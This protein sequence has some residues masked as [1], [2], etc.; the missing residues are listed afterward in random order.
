MRTRLIAILLFL[1]AAVPALAGIRVEEVTAGADGYIRGERWIPVVF[2]LQGAGGSFQGVIEV[3]RGNTIFR[4]S[5]DLGAG[6]SKRVELMVYQSSY[7]DPIEYRI[8]DSQEK[9]ITRNRID[10]RILNYQDNVLLVIS[11]T[12]FS[13]QF[14]NGV[15]NPWGGKTF[16][17]YMDPGQMFSEPI[18]YSAVDAVALGNVSLPEIAPA[19]R[20]ALLLYAATGGTLICSA[21]TNLSVLQDPA[22]RYVLPS[23]SAELTL[24]NHGEFLVSRWTARST[25]AFPALTIPA[26]EVRPGPADN[27]L[28][29]QTADLSLVTSS[30]FYKGNIIYFAFDYTRMPEDVGSIFPGYWNDLIYPTTSGPPAFGRPFRQ[31]LENNPR[32]QRFLYNIP[33]L[34]LPDV[35]WFALFFFVYLIAIGPLQ[36]LILTRLKKNALL[37][38]TFPVIILAFTGAALG[39]GKFR[40]NTDQRIR[41]VQVLDA[42][43][44]LGMQ[45][46]Y[47]AFGTALSESGKFTYQAVPENSF[48]T[49]AA[50]QAF[51]YLPEP[52]TLSEDLPHCIV[53]ENVKTWT[54][55]TF[56]AVSAEPLALP[57]AVTAEIDG[58][59]LTGTV[60]NSGQTAITNSFFVYD[61]KNSAPIGRLNAGGTLPFSLELNNTSPPPF[62]ESHLRGLLDLHG[63]SLTN[64]HFFFGEILDEPGAIAIN[65]QDRPTDCLQYIAVYINL[66]QRGPSNAWAP[67][68]GSP[69]VYR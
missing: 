12:D 61:S 60:T 42:F 4:K 8:R 34:A 35:K 2:Q 16:V 19:A 10:T 45:Y 57:V 22:V 14:L 1:S 47:Q 36:Y 18:A 17:S 62:A 58:G 53:G 48:M 5:V 27:V 54:Y 26:Q 55:R 6:A 51:T 33:G 28:V 39:Y 69:M 38:T 11:G 3:V 66:R 21:A 59:K 20:K 15:Q 25:S 37:W 67:D 7:Y 49:K 56:D 30:P 24:L 13:H 46:R 31:R 32:A 44:S 65:G 63:L 43:P 29:A 64:A 52:F 68:Y 23:I 40:R 9:V 41:H 50:L